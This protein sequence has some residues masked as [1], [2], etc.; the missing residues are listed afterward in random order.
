MTKHDEM[1][2]ADLDLFAMLV[3]KRFRDEGR[4]RA[5]ARQDYRVVASGR[6]G[7]GRPDVHADVDLG[8]GLRVRVQDHWIGEGW[9]DIGR[10][11]DISEAFA[12]AIEETLDT[13][14][15]LRGMIRDV[16]AEAKRQVARANRRGLPWRVA[17]VEPSPV[18]ADRLEGPAVTLTMEIAARTPV[19]A[20]FAVD[21]YCADDVATELDAIREEQTR[22]AWA[23]ESHAHAGATGAIDAV[24]HADLVAAGEDVPAILR[25]L[26]ESREWVIGHIDRSGRRRVLYWK[27]AV[28][29][30]HVHL[31]EDAKWNEGKVD[32]RDAPA[33]I[34]GRIA[35]RRL[36]ALMPS[37]ILEGVTVR[38]VW[39]KPG[40]SGTVYC[41]A[42]TLLFDAASGQTWAPEPHQLAA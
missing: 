4:Q 34:D 39:G 18:D 11:V 26:A 15:E 5:P 41:D 40:G 28:V 24:V 20:T 32:F 19:P 16:K 36:S 2:T 9:D 1:T 38:R 22:L 10:L 3:A 31:D 42:P 29:Q 27:D 35:G 8:R 17:A 14:D 13:A 30:G 21:V 12:R 33:W 6:Y 7:E 23:W 37:P 25:R